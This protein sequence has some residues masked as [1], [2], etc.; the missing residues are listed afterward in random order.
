MAVA[1]IESSAPI[2]D[3]LID[4]CGR[5]VAVPKSP[6]RIVCLCPSLTETLVALGLG[7]RLVGRTRYCIHPQ[8]AI[9]QVAV[10]GGT[11][12]LDF[13]VLTSL[14][15]DFVIAEKEENRLEDVEAIEQI[16]PVYVCDIQTVDDAL[17]SIGTLA[18]LTQSVAAGEKLRQQIQQAWTTLPRVQSPPRILYLIWRKPWMAAGGDTYI[19]SV[20]QRLGFSNVA[21]DLAGRYP[22]IDAQ[23]MR[24]LDVDLVLLSSEPYP[25]K[26]EHMVEIES[27]LPQAKARLVDGEMFS[28]YGSRML[29]AADYLARL[30]SAIEAE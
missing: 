27:L 17:A 10:V 23:I 4:A 30:V 28:W 1:V 3:S 18:A 21:V 11:K 24:Q 13:D 19:D 9:E 20:L 5:S 22:Q 29:P 15:P 12:K 6:Q 2:V 16:C 26:S 7:E 25:F 14:A 8:P